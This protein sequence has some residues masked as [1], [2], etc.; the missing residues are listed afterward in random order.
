MT[1]ASLDQMVT[2][3]DGYRLTLKYRGGEKTIVVAPDTPI[4]TLVA[5]DRSELRPGAQ[6]IAST[7]KNS[8]G[9][10]DA[11]RFLV[12]RDGLAPPM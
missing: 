10:Y 11:P 12:G 2:A 8:D 7:L 6:V 3:N 9:T 5:G 1:N 4:V